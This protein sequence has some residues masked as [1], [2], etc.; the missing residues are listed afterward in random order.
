MSRH[1]ITF[2]YFHF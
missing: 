2:N 1:M